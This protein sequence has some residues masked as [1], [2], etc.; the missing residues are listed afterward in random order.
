MNS[1]LDNDA[2]VALRVETGRAID[3]QT[4]KLDHRLHALCTFLSLA[5]AAFLLSSVLLAVLLYE[6]LMRI[7]AE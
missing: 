5:T 6:V 3:R 4:R 1:P 2:I 7:A